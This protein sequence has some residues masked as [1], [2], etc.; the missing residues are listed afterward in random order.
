MDERDDWR[1]AAVRLSKLA[2][3][4]AELSAALACFE[5]DFDEAPGFAWVHPSL[6]LRMDMVTRSR[7]NA[8]SSR[9]VAWRAFGL[10]LEADPTVEAGVVHLVAPPEGWWTPGCEERWLERRRV[11]AV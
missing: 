4:E 5:A 2:R 10:R 9:V 3:W 1:V 7:A 8:A 11:E 6:L